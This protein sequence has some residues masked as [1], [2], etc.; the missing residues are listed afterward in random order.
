[1]VETARHVRALFAV[2]ARAARDAVAA[3]STVIEAAENVAVDEVIGLL[4]LGSV[5]SCE[6]G[7]FEE[8][9]ELAE[10][11]LLCSQLSHE[12]AA[13][14]SALVALG[15]A[16]SRLRRNEESAEAGREALSLLDGTDYR[17]LPLIGRA[18]MVIGETRRYDS[19][20]EWLEQLQFAFD[21]FTAASD[22]DGAGEAARLAYYLLSTTAGAE[23]DLWSRRAR[24]LTESD[25]FRGRAW[26]ARAE[27]YSELARGNYERAWDVAEDASALAE[28]ATIRDIR[29][30]SVGIMIEAAAHTSRYRSAIE[31]R[32]ESLEE[33]SVDDHKRY[34]LCVSSSLA[35]ARAGDVQGAMRELDLARG[36]VPKFGP[37]EL[38]DLESMLGDVLYVIGD[39]LGA[40]EA[41]GRARKAMEESGERMPT[42]TAELGLLRARR[43]LG[44][45]DDLRAVLAVAT[46]LRRLEAC[47]WL[48]ILLATWPI[49]L[50]PLLGPV[51]E[52]ALAIRHERSG[53]WAAA[54]AAWATL[55]V[56]EDLA[57]ALERSGEPARAAD[58]RAILRAD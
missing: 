15:R 21:A 56:S 29:L 31:L 36:L 44:E 49:E 27:M 25:D 2:E 19:F 54:A 28:S 22:F 14:P 26:I 24:E 8:A 39:D 42:A 5:A 37:V 45:P 17:D 12:T 33:M 52:E 40:I 35:M 38:C 1:V 46:E 4:L 30:E 58:V 53:D 50:E 9:A 51:P 41:Y 6:M 3:A 11:A 20:D 10:R 13:R 7:D 43:R 23:Y 55:G 57:R 47:G 34:Q 16:Y 48:E 18:H 32:A